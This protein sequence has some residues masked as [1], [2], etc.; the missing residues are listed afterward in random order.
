MIQY[1]YE[2]LATIGETLSQFPLWVWVIV[3]LPLPLIIW[4]ILRNIIDYDG[5]PDYNDYHINI[6]T[7]NIKHEHI[8]SE[9]YYVKCEYC[10][11]KDMEFNKNYPI[12][13]CIHCNAPINYDNPETIIKETIRFEEKL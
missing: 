4:S 7:S 1:L 9:K 10:S 3:F 8:L 2:N 6:G 11:S 13:N 12:K 5:M